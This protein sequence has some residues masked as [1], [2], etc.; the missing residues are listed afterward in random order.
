MTARPLRRVV[1]PTLILLGSLVAL[2]PRPAHASGASG[3][4]S[5]SETPSAPEIDLSPEEKAAAARKSAMET[6]DKNFE[7]TE[8]A[9]EEMAEAR[10]LK[11]E[12]EGSAKKAADLRESAIKRYRKAIDGF[13]KAV[14]LDPGF[15]E[16]WNMLG[17]SYRKIGQMGE[18]FKAYE[19]CLKLKPDYDLAHEYL[20]EAWLQAGDLDKAKAELAWLV[21]H[22]SP[23]A[24]N[25]SAAIDKVVAGET[26]FLGTDW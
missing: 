19:T 15:H 25:L 20:G 1:V 17:Y 10:R 12:G 5:S 24:A 6:Y 11:A 26:A 16:A 18:A 2:A 4:G 21:E 8:K 13:R 3:G 9:G 22:K 14:K 23:E 7:Q